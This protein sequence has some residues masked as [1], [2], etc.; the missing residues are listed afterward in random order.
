MLLDPYV[1][2]TTSIEGEKGNGK[3]TEERTN[4]GNERRQKKERTKVSTILL[5]GGFLQ[6]RIFLPV[7]FMI[8]LS[9]NI[10]SCS[11][12]VATLWDKIVE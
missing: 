3:K 2:D 12:P 5:E 8:F 1:V 10:R 11:Y 9:V 4:K 7:I 6:S